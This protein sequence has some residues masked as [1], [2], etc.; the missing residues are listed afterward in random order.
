MLLCVDVQ[1]KHIPSSLK[2]LKY[3]IVTSYIY[4]VLI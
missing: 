4:L 1:H 2:V 3:I